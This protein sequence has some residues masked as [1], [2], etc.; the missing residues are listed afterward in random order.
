VVY[1][2]RNLL[3]RRGY[4]VNGASSGEKNNGIFKNENADLMLLD[5]IMPGLKGI[6]IV[7]N[8]QKQIHQR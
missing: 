5:I 6:E 1:I 2:L 8:R 7:K 4:N 3:S